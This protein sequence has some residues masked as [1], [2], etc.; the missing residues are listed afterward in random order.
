MHAVLN[1]GE[2]LQEQKPMVALLC[3]DPGLLK[4]TSETIMMRLC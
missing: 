4:Q 3:L 2:W 1:G